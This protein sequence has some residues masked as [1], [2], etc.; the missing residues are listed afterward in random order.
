[1]LLNRIVKGFCSLYFKVIYSLNFSNFRY[2]REVDEYHKKNAAKASANNVQN[3][4]K[5]T[6]QQT[7][8]Q[9]NTLYLTIL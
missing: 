7:T 2:I 1:M 3:T 8:K 6:S 9:V 4:A 5:E